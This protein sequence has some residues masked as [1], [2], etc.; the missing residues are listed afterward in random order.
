MSKRIAVRTWDLG[1][2]VLVVLAVGA[3]LIRVVADTSMERFRIECFMAVAVWLC[4]LESIYVL[5]EPMRDH[6]PDRAK[7]V[8]RYLNVASAALCVG[9]LYLLAPR[10]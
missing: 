4:S 6:R 10:T 8:G 7:V 1:G 5:L 2:G 3:L 9:I